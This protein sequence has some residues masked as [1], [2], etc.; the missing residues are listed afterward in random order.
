MALNT[1][2]RSSELKATPRDPSGFLG[3]FGRVGTWH[4]KKPKMSFQSQEEDTLKISGIA[5]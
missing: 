2:S 4:N 5:E 3:Y 1:K